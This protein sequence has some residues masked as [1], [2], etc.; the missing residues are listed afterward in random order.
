MGAFLI[1][2]AMHFGALLLMY[3]C[4]RWLLRSGELFP[5]PVL[6]WKLPLVSTG[7]VLASSLTLE[8]GKRS[9]ARGDRR[10]LVGSLG[11]TIVLGAAFVVL[12]GFLYHQLL[13]LDIGFGRSAQ[14]AIFWGLHWA[15]VAHVLVGLA[16]LGVLWGRAREGLYSA[17]R[18]IGVRLWTW[19]WHFVGVVW[20]AVYLLVY[21]L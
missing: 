18:Y 21:V 13:S 12:Q 3:G 11:S 5:M 17:P 14:T 19:Y 6:P 8:A 16:A 1:S 2:W 10:L 20:A 9:I 4:T 15:H 7:L